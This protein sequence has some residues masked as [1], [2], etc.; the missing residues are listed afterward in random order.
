MVFIRL[1]TDLASRV[2]LAKLSC[3]LFACSCYWQIKMGLLVYSMLG[4][5]AFTHL[6]FACILTFKCGILSLI[7]I[8]LVEVTLVIFMEILFRYNF[9]SLLNV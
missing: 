2:L 3:F 7:L 5:T 4:L 8:F 6:L 1:L 9:F